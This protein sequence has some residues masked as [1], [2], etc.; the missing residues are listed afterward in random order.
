MFDSFIWEIAEWAGRSN[1]WFDFVEMVVEE[2][3]LCSKAENDDLLAS[4]KGVNDVIFH[5]CCHVLEN[6]STSGAHCPLIHPVLV[7]VTFD[8]LFYCVQ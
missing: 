8:D 5:G 3:V 7:F 2:C 1:V 6:A 4:L